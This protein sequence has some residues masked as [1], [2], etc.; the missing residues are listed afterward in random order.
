MG[1]HSCPRSRDAYLDQARKL[2]ASAWPQV[3]SPPGQGPTTHHMQVLP[4]PVKQARVAFVLHP[5]WVLKE[6]L[7]APSNGAEP[8][9]PLR[10]PHLTQRKLKY[11]Y[12]PPCL[13]H[14]EGA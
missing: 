7:P 11:S 13:R 4:V 2:Q 9:G 10:P 5:K 12:I 1:G 3:A 8:P 14:E 6:L